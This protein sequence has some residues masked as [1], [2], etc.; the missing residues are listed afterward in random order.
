MIVRKSLLL[1]LLLVFGA[2][3][4]Q[5]SPQAIRG[6]MSDAERARFDGLRTSG[7]DALYNLDY[8]TAQ[9]AFKEIE[10]L[11]PDHPAGPQFQAA[12]IWSRALWKASPN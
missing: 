5:Q 11:F 8:E 2:A 4:A 9:S 10:R 1:L 3:Q 12:L 6:G 7:F